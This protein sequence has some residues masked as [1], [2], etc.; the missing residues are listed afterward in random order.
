MCVLRRNAAVQPETR[1]K[2]QR[3]VRQTARRTRRSRKTELGVPLPAGPREPDGTGVRLFQRPGTLP[4][5]GRLLRLS[6]GRS[7]YLT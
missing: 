7:E 3:G 2:D 1:A 4:E 5:G 6:L